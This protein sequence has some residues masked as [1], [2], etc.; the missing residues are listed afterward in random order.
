MVDYMPSLIGQK[1]YLNFYVYVEKTNTS[2]PYIV[3]S[4]NIQG[5]EVIWN[6][7]FDG[8]ISN[9]INPNNATELSKTIFCLNGVNLLNGIALLSP[10]PC[11]Q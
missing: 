11:F 5:N 1:V 3:K 7:T 10:S 8:N 6:M 4:E 9:A 2:S